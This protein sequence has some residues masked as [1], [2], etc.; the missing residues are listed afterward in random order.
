MLPGDE[1]SVRIRHIGM[2]QV[3]PPPSWNGPHF[4]C[5]VSG[6]FQGQDFLSR[7]VCLWGCLVCEQLKRFVKAGSVDFQQDDCQGNPVVA[8]VQRHGTP[9]G[10]LVALA[11]NGYALTTEGSTIF[12]SPL[13]NEL[14][15]KISGDFNPIHINPYF[16]CY[17]SLPGTITHGLWSSAATRK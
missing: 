8:Y 16:S 15:S 3:R 4:P 13:T 1:P 11:N 10:R 7:R 12:N 5:S 2:R 6:Y 17:A 9:Q 14:Y